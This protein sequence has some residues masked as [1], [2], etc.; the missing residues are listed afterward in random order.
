MEAGVHFGHKKERSHPKAKE[1][2]FTLREGVMVIDL[3]QTLDR[4]DTALAYLKKE[5]SLGKTVLFVGTKRQVKDLIKEIAVMLGMPYITKRF[6]GGTLTN[7]ETIKKNITTMESLDAQMKTPEFANLTKKEQ[8]IITDKFE[9]L[10]SFYDGIVTMKRLPDVMFVID[11]KKE[12]LAITEAVRMEIPVVAICDTDADP[13]KI[14]YPIPANDDAPKSVNLM[15]NFIKDS[16]EGTEKKEDIKD[17]KDVEDI[18]DIKVKSKPV[19]EAPKAEEVSEVKT[20]SVKE[21]KA[22]K[23]SK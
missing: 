6:F 12:D 16:L 18:K 9:R 13:R 3:D 11:A 22:V 17:K 19:E 20:E 5:I 4:L 10:N 7:Y 15:L 21:K 2:V 23:K 8:K 1:F 14:T